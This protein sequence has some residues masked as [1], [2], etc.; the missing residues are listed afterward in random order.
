MNKTR[1]LTFV[2]LLAATA[3]VVTGCS[4][5]ADPAASTPAGDAGPVL[6][7]DLVIARAGDVITMNSTASQFNNNSIYVFQQL[8]ESL[9]TV[10]ADGQDLEPL[11]ATGYTVSEDGL[12]YT[13]K[14]REGVNFSDGTPMTAKDVKFSI[15]QDTATAETGWGYVNAA[16][17][18]VKV[19]DDSTVEFD[20]KY[21]WAPIIADLSMFSNAIIPENYGGKTV[22]EFY[23]SPIGTGPF[24]WGEWKKGQ[25][26]TL[27]KNPNYWQSGKPYLD[28]VTW[29]VVPDANTRKLQLQGGQIDINTTPDWSSFAELGSTPGLK[30]DAFPS[31]QHDFVEINQQR[32]PFEDVH[33]RRA[34]AF[35]IDRAA[36]VDAVLFGNGEPANSLLS[37]G[38]PFY[39]KNATGIQYDVE[40]AKAELAM[41]S[42]P[43][44]FS[45]TLLI[46]SGDANRASVAQIM[47][48]QLKEIG[49]TIEIKQLEATA[50]LQADIDSDFDMILSAWTMDI[51]DPDQWTS[52]AVDPASGAN[53]SS[54]FYNSPKA[55]ALNKQ[56]QQEADL[57][58][59]A[60]LYKELQAVT[61]E[62][63]FLTYL[64]YSPYAYAS[65]DKVQ[66]FHVTPLGNY[67]V[68]DIYKTK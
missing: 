11:L 64:Y 26:L 67:H 52:F 23:E 56:A 65:T 33:V 24:M 38:T 2:G 63:A 66:G 1:P 28:S 9:F 46:R 51:P 16:I 53:S 58:K 49:I 3:L 40:Q 6:G 39:D 37:P 10:S 59:R 27:V 17:K 62:D 50:A 60:E 8:G 42:Q 13:V 14:L 44:G 21:Q 30:V 35:A 48:D 54:T 31:T 34:I 36:L 45:T 57:D 20:L 12:T 68:E 32:A 25:S 18:E 5:T 22:D 43:N 7:G 55:I 15:D 61:G 4:A 29:N 19:V 47:Q 41:S